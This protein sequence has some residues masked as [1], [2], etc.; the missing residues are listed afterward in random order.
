MRKRTTESIENELDKLD[1]RELS[2][3]KTY[4]VKCKRLRK[5]QLSMEMDRRKRVKIIR[6]RAVLQESL[7]TS[8]SKCIST[9][10]E[11]DS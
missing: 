6:R 9:Q 7:V 1:E 5:L 11:D 10:M 8:D 3:M 2:L 4:S